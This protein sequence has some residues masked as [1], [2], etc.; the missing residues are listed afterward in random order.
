MDKEKKL[1][2]KPFSV[3]EITDK[4]E[5]AEVEKISFSLDKDEKVL[6]V[7]RRM[8]DLSVSGT[9]FATN[10]RI[11]LADRGVVNGFSYDQLSDV[12]LTLAP[13]SYTL[14]IK[15]R[16][17]SYPNQTI[18]ELQRKMTEIH[19]QIEWK[20]N[21]GFISGIPRNKGDLLFQVVQYGISEAK[22]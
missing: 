5:L 2:K 9:V 11:I 1:E 6:V 8:P 4:E 12:R 18:L 16:N 3:P 14:V 13:H 15:I 10:K 20:E 22:T 19:G 17:G 21:T 7:V